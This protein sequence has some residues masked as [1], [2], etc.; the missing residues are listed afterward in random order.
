ML[1][2]D[3]AKRSLRKKMQTRRRDMFNAASHAGETV[4]RIASSHGLIG[5]ED[6]AALYWPMNEELDCRPLIRELLQSGRR[7]VLP[8]T[9]EKHK[10]LI[11]RR[12]TA[13]TTL[14]PGPFG[15]QEPPP[16]AHMLEP[17]ILF[18]P[19][20]AFDS[21]GRRLGYGGGY[22]DRTLAKLRKDRAVRAYGLA[23][24]GQEIERVPSNALDELLDGILTEKGYRQFRSS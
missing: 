17:N 22:Y 14:R 13:D 6:V 2:I 24:A 21:A 19:L 10:P 16:G 12:F 18:L 4:T 11:F 3:S 7:V 9:V 5:L 23:F 15:T 8:V 1:P 20:L